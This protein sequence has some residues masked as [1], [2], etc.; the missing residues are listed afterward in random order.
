MAKKYDIYGMG[1]A[2]V[3]IVTEVD[4][5]FFATNGI[6]K[7]VMTLVDEER[8]AALVTAID[9]LA[10]DKQ[11]GGSAANTVIGAAQ[12]GASVFYSC[13]VAQD[14]LGEFYIADLQANGAD[15]NLISGQLP[16]GTT[17][18]CLV[19]T[20]A[21]A[22]RTMNTFLGITASYSEDN[23]ATSALLDS[24]YLYIE[25]YLVTSD[26][27]REAMKSAKAI[28]QQ[29]GVKVAL[30]FS[31]PAMVKY[32]G[33]GMK[34]VVGDGVDLLFCNE[35]EAMIFTGADSEEAAFE[36]LK[37]SAK[38]FVMTLGPKG[39]LVW[40]GSQSI[41]IAPVPTKA[42][43]TNGAGDL[44]AG[45]FLYGITNGLSHAEAG[46]LASRA[47]SAVV[48]KFGPRLSKAQAKALL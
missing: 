22:E 2:L 27:G 19:M 8:Q 45:A 10:A 11:C 6:E 9:M 23:I 46:A 28:A 14:E 39:A 42:V 3:D 26:N 4:D 15:T 12:F 44:F 35:E 38:Q 18:K 5:A 37:A 31:D 43:D 25:G 41:P 36:A 21:D 20:T 17:G 1:N 30:T 24:E 34:E 33:D 40:D 29:S 16:Q 32:F 47:S 13:K 7:G 48:S